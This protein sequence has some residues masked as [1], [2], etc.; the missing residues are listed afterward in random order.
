MTA[1]IIIALI[2]IVIYWFFSRKEKDSKDIISQTNRATV[3][4]V[5]IIEEPK[6]EEPEEEIFIDENGLKYKNINKT[7]EIPRKTYLYGTLHG[8]YWGEI[9]TLKEEEY[10]R[11]RFYD[12]NIYEAEV[13][14][15]SV[16]KTCT[17]I[18][19]EKSVCDGFHT[20]SEGQFDFKPDT[21][22][23]KEKLPPAIPCT[24]SIKGNSGEYSIVIHEPQVRDV[25]FSRKLHQ[26]E[27]TEIFG[28]IEAEIT[29]Y[30]LDFTIEEYIEREYVVDNTGTQVPKPVTGQTKLSETLVPTGNVEYKSGY[31]RTEYYYSDY[32]TK[33]WGKWKYTRP[34]KTSSTEGCLSSGLGIIGVIIGIAFLLLL[35]PRLAFILPFLLIALI[36]RFIPPGAWTWIFRIIGGFLLI[37]FIVSLINSLSHSTRTYIPNPIAQDKPEE[38][39]PQY[40]PVADTTNNTILQDTLITHYRNWHDYT[41]NNYEGK[42]WIRKSALLNAQNYKSNLSIIENNERNYDEIIFRLKEND[43]NNLPG[44]YNLFDSLKAASN[45]STSGFA[46]MIVSFVQDIPYSVVL[47][48]ACD[49]SLYADD[50]IRNYL[51]SSDAKCDGYEK[52]G[53]NTPVEFMAT[54]QGDC[55]TRTLL[56]YTFLSHYGYDVALLSSEYYNH[57]IIG[58]NLPY[59]GIAYQ[60]NTQRYILWETTAPNIKPGI[61]PN[62]ISNINYWRISLKS[63]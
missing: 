14:T 24:I 10:E 51:L 36:F 40:N 13:K 62:E 21:T 63:K 22:F 33:Y 42:F 29:G 39:K 52:F 41:G 3:E 16:N 15:K 32:K 17:C 25:K 6:V 48:N 4:N 56:I 8:K 12:F 60:Y 1:F 9:D 61:L 5:E 57:S 45:L 18:T 49:P 20:E 30:I 2:I 34:I 26:D 11:L 31:Q 28:T 50:F 46:E 27:G 43:K 58:I 19:S 53:I 7:R 44:V 23:P 59:D 47:P 38:R 54:L 35:L 37:A 55:D